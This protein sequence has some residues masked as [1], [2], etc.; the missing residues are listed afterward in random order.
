MVMQ[1][2]APLT[3]GVARRAGGFT[4]LSVL[5]IVAILTAGLALIGEVWHTSAMREKEADLLFAGNQYRKAIARYY[6]SGPQ[7]Q[8]P[9]A[10]DDLIKDP[11]RPGAERYLR[12]LY[13]DPVTGKEWILVKAP[14][15]GILGVH[16]ASEDKPFKTARFK[17]RD[18][19]FEGAQKYSD[20]KFV[21][22]PQAAPA[23]TKP[24]AKPASK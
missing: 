21:Y 1:A 12:K 24:A 14:D 22:M 13:P 20:W 2:F 4:Y 17:V 3:R 9:R 8:Y 16:S 15:G 11:R 23:A 19:S 6:L 7:R 18:A 10:L 5:F